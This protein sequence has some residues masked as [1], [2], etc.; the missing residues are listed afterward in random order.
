MRRNCYLVP[1]RSVILGIVL[2]VALLFGEPMIL[3]QAQRSRLATPICAIVQGQLFCYGTNATQRVMT[4]PEVTVTECVIAPGGG[5]VLYRAISAEKTSIQVA[6]IAASDPAQSVWEVDPAAPLPSQSD[7]T[8]ATLAWSPDGTTIAYITAAGLRVAFP[9]QT[10]A[11]IFVNFIDQPYSDL[12]F[13]PSGARLAVRATDDTWT[14]FQIDGR[15]SASVALTP[16]RS[17]K[18]TAEFAWFNDD[19]LLLAPQIGGLY[20]ATA[21][22]NS[23]LTN[24][25]VTGLY[26]H[27]IRLEDG[28]IRALLEEVG[29]GYGTTVSISAEG[30]V[31]PLTEWQFDTRLQWT[32]AG[33]WLIYIT[34]GTPIMVDPVTGYEDTLPLRDVS[35][36]TWEPLRIE[37]VPSTALDADLYFLAPD[38]NGINQ[39]WRALR[40]GGAG[41][42]QLTSSS[43]TVESY[44][45]SPNKRYAAVIEAQ[46]L[47]VIRLF[48]EGAATATP[49]SAGR[50]VPPALAVVIPL[51]DLSV[52]TPIGVEWSPDSTRIIVAVGGQISAVRL[53]DAGYLLPT[54]TNLATNPAESY[55]GLQ[56]S[57][58][59][60]Q[61]LA[62]VAPPPTDQG[63][64]GNQRTF[65][66]VTLQDGAFEPLITIAKGDSLTWR[67]P[68][69]NRTGLVWTQQ[70]ENGRGAVKYLT[71]QGAL[72]AIL[73]Q[74]DAP[75]VTAQILRNV[76]EPP[77]LVMTSLGWPRGPLAISFMVIN[78]GTVQAI[79]APFLAVA[80]PVISPTGRLAYMVQ[81]TAPTPESASNNQLLILD[82]QN[83]IKIALQGATNVSA[84]RWIF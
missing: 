35:Q 46:K 42:Q 71:V 84:L 70:S 38:A 47:S 2:G 69:D 81:P 74:A 44:A 39:L 1:L 28:T 67:N 31:T 76:T 63:E 54:I 83:G 33:R 55:S 24:L 8:W 18:L 20:T 62:E 53:D 19:L 57:P 13:S 79:N 82:L 26:T 21:A 64:S 17:F 9:Q 49:P 40:S 29:R 60:T 37:T 45:I 58:S 48:P 56:M 36:L 61:V 30:V 73:Y 78:Q 23:A 14:V 75:I 5:Y 65:R 59:G 34:S 66:V 80:P 51:G 15:F 10:N 11:P 77:L 43:Q 27:L 68:N 52:T 3:T 22:A 16:V 4:P 25:N 32:Q 7:P 50:A 72:E 41:I 6:S 12:R